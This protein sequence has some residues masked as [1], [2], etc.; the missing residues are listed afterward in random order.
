MGRDASGNLH[1]PGGEGA[2]N[3]MLLSDDRP[4]KRR[5]VSPMSACPPCVLLPSSYLCQY[6]SFFIT[7]TSISNSNFYLCLLSLSQTSVLHE[8]KNDIWFILGIPASHRAGT[9]QAP[10]C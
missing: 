1:H 6:F 4:G 7:L 2:P 10:N 3:A 8:I 5:Q 9:Q